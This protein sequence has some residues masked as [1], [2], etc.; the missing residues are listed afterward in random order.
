MQKGI[1]CQP[2]GIY[3]TT[4]RDMMP[5]SCYRPAGHNVL[6]TGSW[7]L[8]RST[9]TTECIG[10]VSPG[11]YKYNH[12]TPKERMTVGESAGASHYV[13]HKK[14]LLALAGRLLRK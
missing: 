8:T 14:L 11:C 6:S 5:W 9:R 3:Y 10:P 12:A 4:T 1:L 7:P 2:K 13:V